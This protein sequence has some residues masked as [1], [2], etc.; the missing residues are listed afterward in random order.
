MNTYCDL[1]ILGNKLVPEQIDVIDSIILV[2]TKEQDV[3]K[4]WMYSTVWK[5]SKYGVF[6]GPYFNVFGLNRRD[7]PHSDWIQKDTE[8]LSVFS[9][10]TI[11]YGPEKLR[12]WIL[13]PQ[14]S[15]VVTY[16]LVL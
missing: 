13:F 2:V 1:S 7:N 5:L 14:C 8:Y 11:K 10:N 3:I 6:S 15:V 4:L 16:I 9:P 12:I